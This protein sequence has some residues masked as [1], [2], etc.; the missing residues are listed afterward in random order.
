MGSWC[1]S[2]VVLAIAGGCAQ[3]SGA[4]GVVTPDHEGTG[5]AAGAPLRILP[6]AA[7]TL[8]TG[9][10][11][12]SRVQ[13]LPDPWTEP[14]W[15]E[16]AGGAGTG[17]EGAAGGAA[18]VGAARGGTP[19]GDLAGVTPELSFFGCPAEERC[20][21]DDGLCGT[22][23]GQGRCASR[24]PCE[25][26]GRVCGCDGNW[27]PSEC[28]AAAAGVDVDAGARC[29]APPG[30]FACGPGACPMG[31]SACGFTVAEVGG[32]LY[33]FHCLELTT[34][35]AARVLTG[36]FSECEF[37]SPDPCGR[38]SILD[39]DG[40]RAIYTWCSDF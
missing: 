32:G 35:F 17:G 7:G 26:A 9:N 28:A 31:T 18:G 34:D 8:G 30:S 39:V 12:C 23:K 4:D 3:A 40:G 27:Y 20:V 24:V 13:R 6:A 19:P 33:G 38:C 14:S 5:G 21:F 15:S 22:G 37:V 29:A 16:G 36:A 2:A 1:A 25:E 11:L 10:G